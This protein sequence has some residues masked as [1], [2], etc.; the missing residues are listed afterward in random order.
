MAP[1][2]DHRVKGRVGWKE[3][4]RILADLREWVGEHGLTSPLPCGLTIGVDADRKVGKALGVSERS[5]ANLRRSLLPPKETKGPAKGH[6]KGRG[7][8]TD[9][10]I[11]DRTAQIIAAAPRG[12]K[13]WV[14]C[15]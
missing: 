2:V 15:N 13:E 9:A 7:G 6:G 3:Q 14:Q 11:A 1:R 10:Q 4:R 5:I 12:W 8:L